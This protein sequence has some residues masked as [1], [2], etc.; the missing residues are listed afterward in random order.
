MPETY[1]MEYPALF[2]TRGGRAGKKNKGIATRNGK[3]YE[4]RM[5]ADKRRG[6][7]TVDLPKEMTKAYSRLTRQLDRIEKEEQEHLSRLCEQ[8]DMYLEEQY[9]EEKRREEENEMWSWD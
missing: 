6:T 7:K 4:R 3:Y 9:R 5:H 2:N 8:Y 1:S